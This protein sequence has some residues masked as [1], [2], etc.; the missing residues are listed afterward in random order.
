MQN[1]QTTKNKSDVQ[2]ESE[3]C[4]CGINQVQLILMW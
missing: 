3:T 4:A 1:S 2:K